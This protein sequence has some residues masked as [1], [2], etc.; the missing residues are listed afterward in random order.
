MSMKQREIMNMLDKA[1]AFCQGKSHYLPE[2][3]SLPAEFYAKNSG[4][5]TEKSH[6]QLCPNNLSIPPTIAKA[7]LSEA[8][9]HHLEYVNDTIWLRNMAYHIMTRDQ[10]L[11]ATFNPPDADLLDQLLKKGDGRY[12]IPATVHPELL[13][14]AKKSVTR[15]SGNARKRCIEQFGTPAIEIAKNI[16]KS[17]TLRR[18]AICKKQARN[19]WITECC[20]RPIHKSCSLN[21]KCSKCKGPEYIVTI[22]VKQ[23]NKVYEVKTEGPEEKIKKHE[24]K[25]RVLRAQLGNN[26]ESEALLEEDSLFENKDREE[27]KKGSHDEDVKANANKGKGEAVENLVGKGQADQ[28]LNPK[29]SKDIGKLDDA[30]LWKLYESG[31]INGVSMVQLQELLKVRNLKVGQVDRA[32]ILSSL[33]KHLEAK[34]KGKQF[35]KYYAIRIVPQSIQLHLGYILYQC[36]RMYCRIYYVDIKQLTT[37]QEMPHNVSPSTR[38]VMLPSLHQHVPLSI[39]YV[40]SCSIYHVL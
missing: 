4:I 24:D 15:R 38:Q 13:E 28:D 19:L 40:F 3:P 7:A 30:E 10:R 33:K 31:E 29:K 32:G 18:C 34:V 12:A 21:K 36:L 9:F 25:I 6:I 20:K 8:G 14:L 5:F 39:S 11:K 2:P 37:C 35:L 23:W 16:L 27:L 26:S 17:Y 1:E 22:K